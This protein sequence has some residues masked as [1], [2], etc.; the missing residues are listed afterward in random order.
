M[1]SISLSLKTVTISVHF[2][3]PGVDNQK[4]YKIV[5]C[6]NAIAIR[7]ANEETSFDSRELVYEKNREQLH[8]QFR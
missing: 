6:T 8:S 4:W 7:R 1:V 3:F 5:P 2:S